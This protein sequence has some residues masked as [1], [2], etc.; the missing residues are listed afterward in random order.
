MRDPSWRHLLSLFAVLLV[1]TLSTP[2]Y[3]MGGASSKPASSKANNGK[4]QALVIGNSAYAHTSPLENP[5][6]DARLIGAALKNAGFNVRLHTDLTQKQM[7]RAM[8]DF[9]R[10]LRAIG[11]KAVSLVY[12]G[13]HG[14][15]VAGRNYLVPVDANIEVEQDVGIETLAV[16]EM[17][18][19]MEAIDGALSIIILDACRNNPYKRGYRSSVRGLA[20]LKAIKGSIVAYSTAPGTVASDGEGAN[21]PYATALDKY[22][23]IGGLSI[24]K[25]FKNVRVEVDRVTKG[26]QTPW[27]ESSLFGDFVFLP[28][29]AGSGQASSSRQTSNNKNNRG[30]TR[31]A[32]ETAFWNTIKDSDNPA[33]V[34]SYLRTFPS[35]LFAPL[36]KLKLT[37]QKAK[38]Q[39]GL[40]LIKQRR[41]SALIA[42]RGAKNKAMNKARAKRHKPRPRTS[43]EDCLSFYRDDGQDLYCASSVLNAQKGNKYGVASLLDDSNFTAWFEGNKGL[44]VGQWILVDFGEL[45]TIDEITLKNGY[46][47]KENLYY[48]NSRVRTLS[49]VFSGGQKRRSLALKDQPGRQIFQIPGKIKARWVQLKIEAVIKGKKYSDTG[50]NE[51]RVVTS[52]VSN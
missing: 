29:Q 42:A 26:L 28:G 43:K 40:E 16:D 18:G 6:K 15:Q 27:E 32:A 10:D 5:A 31:L 25:M 51:L 24:E 2:L 45:R 14:T 37:A 52:A 36:A 21:S 13:G 30:D 44:G 11:P 41:V 49:L 8:R 33:A 17:L 4:R 23:R 1:C 22:L 39:K 3:A 12:F 50:L 48:N 20:S 47:K 46:N 9:S 19:Q 34:E 35:G 38:R 7:K